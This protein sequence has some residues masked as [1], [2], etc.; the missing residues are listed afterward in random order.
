MIFLYMTRRIFIKFMLQRGYIILIVGAALLIAG[1]VLSV[2]WAGSFANSFL[3][4]G[5][6]LSDVAVAP[7][8]T[9]SNTIQVTDIGHPIALQIHFQSFGQASNT[10]K[11]S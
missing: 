7:S 1:I 5:I 4:Q 10:S 8:G 3:S 6:I 2:V 9:A 11:R